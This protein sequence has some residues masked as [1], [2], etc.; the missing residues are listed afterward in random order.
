MKLHILGICGTFMGGIARLAQQLGHQVAGSDQNVYPPMSE[1]LAR[2]GIAVGQGYEPGRF[3]PR[4]DLVIIGNALSRGN[5]SVEHVL[6]EKIPYISGPQWLAENVLPGRRVFAVSGT[7]GK[8]TT[9]SILAWI[10]HEAG[11]NPGF[12]IGGVPENFG[13]S[14]AIGGS[15]LFVVEADEYDTAFFDKRSKFVHYHPDV[16]IISN[17]E[18]DHADIFPDV[19]AINRQ[20]HH[21]VR[22]VPGNGR[23]IA[24]AASPQIDA[25]L[26]M[27][28]WSP[29]TR[30]G[31]VS[32]DWHSA[33]LNRDYSGFEVIH[34]G[35]TVG[36]VN[37]PLFGEHNAQNALAA[38][39]AAQQA[40]VTPQQACASLSGFASV[41]RRLQLLASVDGVSVYDDFAHHPT[42]IKGALQ[43]L[44][45]RIGEE[46]LIAVLELRS[47][48]MKAGIH[49]HTL[50]GAL[51][52]ADLVC[53]HEPPG[54]GWDLRASLNDLGERLRI[55]PGVADIIGHLAQIRMRHDH[56]LIMSNGGF[57]NI[58]RRFIER[59]SN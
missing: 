27:G 23:I 54:L 24:R 45:S 55:F 15:D 49:K 38:L 5:S 41:K 18:Y 17:I 19:A 36:V 3:D 29:L 7:H 26:G 6:S 44:R 21:L 51:G 30:F 37:W 47:N 14:A 28:N 1:E 16:L 8:T 58:Y 4:P 52:D 10:L 53:V 12:L 46:R 35:Q 11:R 9:A 31:N 39:I 2:L 33:P 43:A 25:V 48:T 20:F 59:L 57:E 34:A 22:T 13:C 32:S 42:A 50:A 40:G 56:V